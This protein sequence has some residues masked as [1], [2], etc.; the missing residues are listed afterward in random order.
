MSP[1]ELPAFLKAIRD[2]A[3]D[4]A[5]ECVMAMAD[6]YRDH[7][8]HVTLQK[9]TNTPFSKTPS[10]PG[11][12]PA[13]ISGELAGS[14]R[15]HLGPSSGMVAHATTAPH[16]VYAR[17]Q[18][19]GGII[20][21]KSRRYLK[22][23]TDYPTSATAFWKSAREGDG[24]FLNFARSVRIPARPYMRPATEETVADGS[25]TRAAMRAFVARVWG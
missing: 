4:A 16:T 20:S 5:P 24:L 6:T 9:Y 3:A 8:S 14:V 15:S 7:V 17:I 18:E 11:Q 25:L 2:R 22:W 19:V 12:P 23:L 21:V 10:P 13:R 1:D